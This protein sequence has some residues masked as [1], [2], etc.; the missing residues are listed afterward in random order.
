MHSHVLPEGVSSTFSPFTA[1]KSPRSSAVDPETTRGP[2]RNKASEC[3]KE[4][5]KTFNA[6][7]AQCTGHSRIQESAAARESYS[8]FNDIRGAFGMALFSISH[9]CSFQKF[10]LNHFLCAVLSF[11]EKWL[12]M[13]GSPNVEDSSDLSPD[14]STSNCTIVIQN[15][16]QSF[17]L[18]SLLSG[19][20]QRPDACLAF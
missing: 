8:V 3:A 4:S 15:R 7:S 9:H 1:R 14:G 10:F 13:P 5:E 16:I 11:L 18:S 20:S 17:P 12:L 6:L 19:R 2:E